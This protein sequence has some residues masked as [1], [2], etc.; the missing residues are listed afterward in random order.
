LAR[1]HYSQMRTPAPPLLAIF[2]SQLQGELLARVLLGP[3]ELTISDL[4]RALGAPVATVHREVARLEDA[5]V[6]T[7]TRVGR[8]R[9]VS[10]N[11]D[12]PALRPLRELVMVTFGPRQVVAE[13]FAG[14]ARADEVLIFG[15]WAARYAG[16]AGRPPGDVDVL[17]V[18]DADRDE[19]FDAAQRA[20]E[21]LGREVNATVVSRQRWSEAAEP[22]LQEVRRRPLVSV[23]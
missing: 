23:A 22:F 4:A 19:V 13:E 5:G 14:I 12:N 9:L 7:S 21:R 18:G 8:A 20:A 16:D 6:L 15:S 3:R 2:R 11:E 1:D 10:A 17:V